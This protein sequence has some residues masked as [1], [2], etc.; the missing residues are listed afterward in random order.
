MTFDKYFSYLD[1]VNIMKQRFVYLV[2]GFIL[3]P[4]DSKRRQNEKYLSYIFTIII[5]FMASY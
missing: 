1:R 3:K 4:Y 5:K 2:A